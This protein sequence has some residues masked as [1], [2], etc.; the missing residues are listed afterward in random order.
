MEPFSFF[1]LA[2][3]IVPVVLDTVG[4][5]ASLRGEINFT[6]AV[7]ARSAWLKVS[8]SGVGPHRRPEHDYERQALL[9]PS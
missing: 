6:P 2:F 7:A 9:A 3:V 5:V 1:M 8:S 4:L